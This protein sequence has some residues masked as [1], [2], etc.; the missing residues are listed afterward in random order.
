[1]QSAVVV[2]TRWR[3]QG[4]VV[5]HVF[6][7]CWASE[8][9]NLI[10][11]PIFVCVADL[12]QTINRFASWPSEPKMIPRAEEHSQAC[13]FPLHEQAGFALSYTYLP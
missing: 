3:G 1:M 7:T 10:P 13:S 4:G 2:P 6:A 12:H 8:R 9:T 5:K 11:S